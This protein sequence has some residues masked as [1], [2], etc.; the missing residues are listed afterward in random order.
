M[1]HETFFSWRLDERSY[2]AVDE[3][4]PLNRNVRAIIFCI[5]RCRLVADS[6]V[7]AYLRTN[8]IYML[9]AK[10]NNLFTQHGGAKSFDCCNETTSLTAMCRIKFPIYIDAYWWGETI[11]IESE[12]IGNLTFVHSQ[13]IQIRVNQNKTASSNSIKANGDEMKQLTD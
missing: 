6:F 10:S 5:F 4:I 9:I 2:L 3:L 8:R 7:V 12:F 11:R 1:N 13:V